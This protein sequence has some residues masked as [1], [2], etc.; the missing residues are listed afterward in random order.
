[1]ERQSAAAVTAQVDRKL[2]VRYRLQIGECAFR[3]HRDIIA[4][5][6]P[7]CDEIKTFQQF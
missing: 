4:V 5:Q 2:Q 3:N 1:M 6:G 7:A